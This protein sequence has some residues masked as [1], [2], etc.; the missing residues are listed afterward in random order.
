MHTTGIESMTS[1]IKSG[2]QDTGCDAELKAWPMERMK[3]VNTVPINAMKMKAMMAGIKTPQW[4]RGFA[5]VIS[6]FDSF[7]N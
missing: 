6:C 4:I 2:N 3:M 7:I 5:R 1:I